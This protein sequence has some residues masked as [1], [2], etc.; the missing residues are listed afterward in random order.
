MNSK[1]LISLCILFLFIAGVLFI[2][3]VH[4]SSRKNS[5]LSVSN[6]TKPASKEK[7]NS[8]DS[9]NINQ[10]RD[11][12][13]RAVSNK[14]QKLSVPSDNDKEI[15]KLINELESEDPDKS[16]KAADSLVELGKMGIPKLAE[17]LKQAGIGLKGQIIFILGRIKD[18]EAVPILMETLKDDNAYLRRNSAEALGKIKDN[19]SLPPLAISLFDDDSG[20][21][22]RS[23]WA[24]GE[25]A[26]TKAVEN[27][28]DRLRDEKQERVKTTV[29]QSLAKLKDSRATG[30]LLAQLKSKNDRSYKNEVVRSLGELGDK[31]ALADLNAYLDE[32]K[33]YHPTEKMVVFQWEQA[34]KIAE[35]AIQKIKNKF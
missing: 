17:S 6:K 1:L 24:L 23:A 13:T 10:K 22:E 28:L 30:L 15:E 33:E 29:V 2:D 20:V 8:L 16:Q 18:K 14:P 27:L 4:F 32:L 19:A 31:S 25:L 21:R 34:M 12:K 9:G 5:I 35:E 26:S 11:L 7:L 3:H